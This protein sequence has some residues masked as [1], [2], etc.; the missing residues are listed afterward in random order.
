[1]LPSVVLKKARRAPWISRPNTLFVVFSLL[2]IVAVGN[3]TW[4][5][6]YPHPC[7]RRKILGCSN[8][9]FQKVSTNQKA[10]FIVKEIRAAKACRHHSE[11]FAPRP[12]QGI[13]A[14][15]MRHRAKHIAEQRPQEPPFHDQTKIPECDSLSS[16]ATLWVHPAIAR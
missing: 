2:F 15:D 1:M 13:D 14:H 10:T 5:V 6:R 4:K 12:K 16:A 11:S 9:K 8:T 7:Y 3:L